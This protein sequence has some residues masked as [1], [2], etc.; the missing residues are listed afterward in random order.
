[1]KITATSETAKVKHYAPA[2]LGNGAISILIGPSGDQDQQIYCGMTPGIWRAG[3]RYDNSGCEL[4]P[5][6]FYR[7][8]VNEPVSEW[9]QGLDPKTG[10]L[11]TRVTYASGKILETECF[12][13][14][15]RDILA[16]RIRLIN[17]VNDSF[18][19]KYEWHPKRVFRSVPEA[20]CIHYEIDGYSEYIGNIWLSSDVSSSHFSAEDGVY[21]L[22]T[23]ASEF[24]IF[25]SFDEKNV[26]SFEQL[27]DETIS[28]WQKYHDE[29][30]IKVPS[31]KIQN[32]YDMCQYHLKISS[33][34]WSIPTGIY[35]THWNG[36][37]FGFDEFFTFMGLLTSGHLST[38]GKIPHFRFNTLEK[39]FSRLESPGAA[40]F[41]WESIEDGSEHAPDG[42]W[43]EHIFQAGNIA[44]SAWNMYRFSGDR[45]LLQ[46]ELYPV[47][48]ALAEWIRIFKTI[49]SEDGSFMPAVCTDLERLGGGKE[50]PFM[51]SC[52]LIA[53]FES[54][55]CAAEILGTD[56]DKVLLW[57]MIASD[58]RK[59]L[60]QKEGRY[61]PYKGE[62]PQSI[63]VLAGIYPYGIISADDPMAHAAL[64]DYSRER[65]SCGNMYAYVATGV[66]SWYACWEALA[67]ARS[68]NGNRAFA[69]LEELAEGCGC[70]SEMYE[71]HKVGKRPW[72]TTAEGIFLQAV[73]ELLLQ[74]RNDEPVIAPALPDV[75]KDFSFRLQGLNGVKIKAEYRGGTLIRK[76]LS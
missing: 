22:E 46:T 43:H 38:A 48:R 1:M 61:I 25:L 76:T 70:F 13:H 65:D 20:G 42:F 47:M 32:L 15:Q 64:E 30:Y 28:E 55:S 54:V 12:C 11:E 56:T 72:F 9:S 51:T 58:F 69:C 2:A 17:W 19:F 52:S 37:Y 44:L 27:K 7:F 40:K 49:R 63:G 10:I 5:F 62:P 74:F 26:C 21:A 18:L 60:P 14:F 66:C 6:G 59:N 33:T 75:W 35:P 71:I 24:T 16:I 31:E 29:T 67:W 68:G 50:K 8:A 57:R 34:Q 45:K 3:F 73:N 53:M 41:A 36:R 4:V 23:N 39:A